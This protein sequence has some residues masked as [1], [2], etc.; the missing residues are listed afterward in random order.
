[1]MKRAPSPLLWLDIWI[2]GCTTSLRMFETMAAVPAVLNARMPMIGA[3]AF[4]PLH[5]NW[6]ELHRMV[7]EKTEA[8]VKASLSVARDMHA[9]QSEMLQ[10]N[11]S[12]GSAALSSARIQYHAVGA[13]GRALA[14]LHAAVTGNAR[15]LQARR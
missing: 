8:F 5:G 6:P 9:I 3:A 4:D 1:M 2:E 7:A 12:V 10:P 14:P 15:R 13:A 11:P